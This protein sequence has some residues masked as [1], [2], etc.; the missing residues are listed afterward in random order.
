[1]TTVLNVPWQYP[2]QVPLYMCVSCCFLKFFFEHSEARCARKMLKKQQG[3]MTS[4]YENIFRITGPLWGES[5]SHRWIPLTKSSRTRSFDAFLICT[6]T[7]GWT[8]NWNA[9]DLR[10]HRVHYDVTVMG[11][12]F[13]C[14]LLH[15]MHPGAISQRRLISP[16]ISSWPLM[17]WLLAFVSCIRK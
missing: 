4:S 14:G 10:R 11:V 1:M 6:S 16:S 2:G 17:P 13:K 3:M 12:R 15:E 5:T 9:G 7:N 8:N